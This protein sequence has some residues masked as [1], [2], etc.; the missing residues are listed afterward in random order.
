DV[1]RSSLAVH[2]TAE[3]RALLA[4]IQKGLADENGMTEQRISHFNVRYDGESHEDVGREGLRALERHYATLV[5]SLD[6]QPQVTIPVILFSQQAYF[7]ASGA[8]AWSGGAYDS[9]DGRIRIPIG[10]LTASL[11]PDMDGVL[12]HEVTHAFIADRSRGAATRE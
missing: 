5:V 2:E 1:L 3:A 6:H 11:T 12:I 7:D 8:P 9:I 10:G 4:R